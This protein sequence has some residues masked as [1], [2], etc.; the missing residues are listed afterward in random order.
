M[1]GYENK[2]G[3]IIGT[4]VVTAVIGAIV[5]GVFECFGINT[6]VIGGILAIIPML[7]MVGFVIW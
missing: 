6:G 4:I 2:T 1:K 5:C 7:F 3:S